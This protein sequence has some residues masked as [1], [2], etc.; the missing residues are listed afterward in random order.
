MPLASAHDPR[1]HRTAKTVAQTAQYGS[2]LTCRIANVRIG[3]PLRTARAA[4]GERGRCSL[5]RKLLS[6]TLSQHFLRD[7]REN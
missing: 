5:L 7:R 6:R 4:A 1:M 2:T 3:G